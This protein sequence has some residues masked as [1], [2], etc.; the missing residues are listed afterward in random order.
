MYTAL[1]VISLLIIAVICVERM[2]MKNEREQ[3]E[4][5]SKGDL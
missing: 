3:Q 1:S 2:A 5:E 4:F